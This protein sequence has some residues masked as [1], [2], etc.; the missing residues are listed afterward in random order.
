MKHRNSKQDGAIPFIVM[1][2][3]A[4]F[5]AGGT[6]GAGIAWWMG[7]NGPT[8]FFSAFAFGVIF[9]LV[10][11]PNAA[12]VIRWGKEVAKELKSGN[13]SSS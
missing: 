10:F 12:P 2:L 5:I 4:V 9:G 7:G 8:I 1:I 11:L 6:L 13:S 3:M